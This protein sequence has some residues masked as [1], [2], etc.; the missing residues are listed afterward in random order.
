MKWI[1]ATALLLV[2]VG[3]VN[4]GLWAIAEVDLVAELFGGNTEAASKVVYALVGAA[5]L[6]AIWRFPQLIKG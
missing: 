4:W 3:A 6:Y 5:G 2:V 1:T